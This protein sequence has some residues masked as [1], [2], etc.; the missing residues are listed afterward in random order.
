MHDT[1]DMFDVRRVVFQYGFA[2][3]ETRRASQ[4]AT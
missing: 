3:R 2:I 4:S 1:F